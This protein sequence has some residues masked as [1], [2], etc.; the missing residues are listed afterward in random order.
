MKH[1]CHAWILFLLIT[2]VGLGL[3]Y[4]GAVV[5]YFRGEAGYNKVTLLWKTL[6]EIDLKAFDV[7]RSLDR[8]NYKKIGS[9]KAQGGPSSPQEYKFEDKSVFKPSERTFY[10]RLKLVNSDDSFTYLPQEVAVTP[11]VSSAR[12]TWGSIKAMF[13]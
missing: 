11:S 3:L 13:R 8:L 7:E 9:V 12:Q 10:Y 5:E 1:V 2:V 4:G 6:A